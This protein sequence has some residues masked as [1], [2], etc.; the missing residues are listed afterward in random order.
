M[1]KT[2]HAFQGGAELLLLLTGSSWLYSTI[3]EKLHNSPDLVSL[4]YFCS[5]CLRVLKTDTGGGSKE[6]KRREEEESMKR[7][8]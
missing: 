7:K 3:T 8:R 5:E 4:Q 2:N 6:E 1:G